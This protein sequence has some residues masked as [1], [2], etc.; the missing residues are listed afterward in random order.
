MTPSPP[1]ARAS[2]DYSPKAGIL[3]GIAMDLSDDSTD[4][5]LDALAV[6]SLAGN[7]PTLVFGGAQDATPS[8]L[9]PPEAALLHVG[10]IVTYHD[11]L[12]QVR[13]VLRFLSAHVSSYRAIVYLRLTQ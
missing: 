12:Y 3:E 11:V 4:A 5:R 6:R 7:S 10:H 8:P 1:G 13:V 2:P 9:A